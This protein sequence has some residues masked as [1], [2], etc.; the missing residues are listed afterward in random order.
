MKGLGQMDHAKLT[1]VAEQTT[2]GELAEIFARKLLQQ[3]Q[4][5][6]KAVCDDVNTTEDDKRPYRNA[7]ANAEALAQQAKDVGFD[8]L[9]KDNLLLDMIEAAIDDYAEE[10]TR[11]I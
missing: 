4:M 7:A 1:E 9:F 8:Q 6:C 3:E 2:I 5:L 11:D 10:Y